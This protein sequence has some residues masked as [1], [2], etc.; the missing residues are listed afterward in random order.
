MIIR[1]IVVKNYKLLKDEVIT[2]NPE[3]NIFVG[4]NDSGKSTILEALSIITTGK[5]NGYYLERKL[6]ANLF[7]SDVRAEFVEDVLNGKYPEPP[8]M[9]FE[10]YFDGDAI[11][12]GTNNTLSED[13]TGINITVSISDENS[14]IYKKM[15]Q[16]GDVKDIPIELYHVSCHYFNG[17]PFS[18]RYG[19]FKSIFIDTTRKEYAG[20]VDSFVS[21]SISEH[22]T[23]EQIRDLAT[24]YKSSRREF[25]END[26]V[27]SLNKTVKE[28]AVI[29]GKQISIDL[30]EDDTE[31]WKRQMAVVVDDVPFENIGFGSQNI[32]KI[33]LALRNADKQANVVLM[34]EPENNLSFSNMTRFVDHVVKSVGKQVFL[35]THSSYIANKLN[36]SNVILVKQGKAVSFNSLSEE[37]KKYFIKLP[38][39]DT[40]RFALSS[41][42]ILV[43][44]PTDDLIIQRAYFDHYGHYPSD[45]GVDIITVGSLAFKRFCDIA[46]LMKKRVAIVTDNDGSIQKN[47][48]EKYEGYYDHECLSFYYEENEDY[49]TIEP[50]VLAVNCDNGVPNEDFKR[51]ISINGSMMNRD[52]DGILGFMSKKANKSE[53]AYRVFEATE[54]INYPD[55]IKKVIC[56][57]EE[58][59]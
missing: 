16:N 10:A 4:D 41:K 38:G 22:L 34:E 32:I 12:K 58:H 46:I 36:L 49:N 3:L 35:S 37:T 44:G 6:K 40:L 19:P 57:Y 51:A 14:E 21:D 47:I 20:L 26:I 45:E 50:S 59:C 25:R 24:A 42:A 17:D 23:E 43:E 33:E 55:Y 2:L 39:Y 27:K 52:Y 8:V 11:Y 5:L 13:T 9:V 18:F 15:L 54:C 7:N 1:K 31:E 53:W 48:Y 30:R 56:C 28:N 29:Q